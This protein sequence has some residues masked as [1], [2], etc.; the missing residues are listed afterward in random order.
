MTAPRAL[1]DARHRLLSLADQLAGPCILIDFAPD[2]GAAQRVEILNGAVGPRPSDAVRSIA[3]HAGVLAGC[4]DAEPDTDTADPHVFYVLHDER[5]IARVYGVTLDAFIDAV[6]SV[7]VLDQADR[8]AA[9]I[10]AL[11]KD[12]L[13]TPPSFDGG[14][15][16]GHL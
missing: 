8:R 5:R 7:A 6:I 12:G 14:R 1:D 11:V 13:Y 16:P 3:R 4:L 15:L 2:V 10:A 9:K